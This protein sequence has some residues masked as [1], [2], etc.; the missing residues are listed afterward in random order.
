[1]ADLRAAPWLAGLIGLGVTCTAAAL[2][3]ELRS[4]ALFHEVDE[5]SRSLTGPEPLSIE[6][7]EYVDALWR[8]SAVL[9]QV[10]SPLAAGA[11]L[12]AIALFAVLALRWQRRERRRA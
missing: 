10:A 5:L 9:H 12:A 1:M 4:A 8:W 7:S 3:V 2:A 6:E 11:V